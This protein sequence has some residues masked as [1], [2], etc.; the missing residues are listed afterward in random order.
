M[1]DGQHRQDWFW[2]KVFL[3]LYIP[4][5]RDYKRRRYLGKYRVP[6]YSRLLLSL[7]SI[8]RLQLWGPGLPML[9]PAQSI[10]ICI[11]SEMI[12]TIFHCNTEQQIERQFQR[13]KGLSFR[14]CSHTRSH[15]HR[16]ALGHMGSWNIT[17]SH[18]PKHEAEEKQ[19][20]RPSP[21]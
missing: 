5:L 14:N 6:V 2:R 19:N 13:K 21:R 8:L 15:L 1:L 7:L 3:S 4:H 10:A 20:K 9:M 12:T 18:A 11:R 16:M 17:R